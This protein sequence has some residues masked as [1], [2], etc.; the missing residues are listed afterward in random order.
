MM[1]GC[2]SSLFT[3]YLLVVTAALGYSSYLF[4][5]EVDSRLD[6]F[7]INLETFSA[8]FEQSLYNE[9]GEELEKSAGVFY[10]R[11]PGMFHWAYREPYSQL[12]ISDGITLWVYD[13]DLEQVI[14]K[15]ISESI[16]NSPAAIL[17]GGININDHYVVIDMGIMDGINWLELTPRDTESQYDSIRLGFKDEELSNMLLFDNLGMK[18]LITFEDIKTNNSLNLELFKF[19]PP[20]GIDIIDNR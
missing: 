11:R 5:D 10:L 1:K 12:I 16:E 15:D 14:I 13:E 17:G 3:C 18:N 7:L 2:L 20:E 19:S 9:V 4:A 6:T 8:A